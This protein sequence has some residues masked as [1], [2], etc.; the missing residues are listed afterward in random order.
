MSAKVI[1]LEQGRHE[2]SVKGV[3]IHELRCEAIALEQLGAFLK[4][5][6]VGL[7]R[8]DIAGADLLVLDPKALGQLPHSANV[9][10]CQAP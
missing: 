8:G 7:V 5:Q 3:P 1:G 2:A 10:R 9:I 4:L 6:G